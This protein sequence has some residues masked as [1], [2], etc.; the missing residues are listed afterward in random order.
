MVTYWTAQPGHCIRNSV[1]V[2]YGISYL[3]ISLSLNILLTLMI[4]TRLVLHSR[5]IRTAMGASSG[6]TGL[7]KT[8][9]TM[10]I[11]SS[12]VFTA[13]SLLFLGFW[14]SRSHIGEVF[15][16]I[17][18]EAQVCALS[19]STWRPSNMVV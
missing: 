13:S 11:E 16:A 2:N 5:N 12:A 10:L 17:Y 15:S 8:V 4:V 1:L 3:S 9:V 7:Y 14:G 18:A 19:P 6:L